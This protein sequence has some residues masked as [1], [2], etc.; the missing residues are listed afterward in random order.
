M[1]FKKYAL[2][3]ASAN[4]GKMA[5]KATVDAPLSLKS[6]PVITK[7]KRAGKPALAQQI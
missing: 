5:I 7:S 2:A 6:G 1:R 3:T 4:E